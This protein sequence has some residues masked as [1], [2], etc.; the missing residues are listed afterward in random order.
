M[1]ASDGVDGL[2]G[3]SVVVKGSAIGTTTDARGNYTLNVPDKNALLIFSFVGYASQTI[4]VNNQTTVDVT[5]IPDDQSLS[6][7]VVI[8]YGNQKK[9]DVTGAVSVADLK[10]VSEIPLSSVDQVL[11]GRVGGVQIT[12]SS[13]Q[14]GAG[15]SI[16]IRGSNSINGN[17][18]PLFVVDGFP[19]IN[20]NGAY[21][22]GGPAGLTNSGSGNPGQG[23]PGGA[24]NWLNP[25]DIESIDVLKDASS[26]AIYG[27][28]GANG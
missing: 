17:N 6:E 22:A 25:A 9:S 2:P 24:L 21:A 13:G 18:E 19:I 12:Q 14:A 11:N 3:V 15:T 10:R 5:L 28:R 26:T 16:R 20:D 8:G 1:K 4:P 7:V 23:N 27:S